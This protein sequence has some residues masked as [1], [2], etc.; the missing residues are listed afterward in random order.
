VAQSSR[1]FYELQT[2]SGYLRAIPFF[3][4]KSPQGTELTNGCS[5][6]ECDAINVSLSPLSYVSYTWE[7]PYFAN[8]RSLIKEERWKDVSSISG[9]SLG[10]FSFFSRNV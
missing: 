1:N 4:T 5:L 10:R 7:W 3:K 2:T 8:Y 6:N 9:D